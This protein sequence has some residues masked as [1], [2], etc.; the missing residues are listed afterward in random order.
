MN[1]LVKHPTKLLNGSIELPSSKSISNRALI[2]QALC[3]DALQI[4]NLS[5][6]KDT[7]VL[8]E[9]LNGNDRVINIGD[10]GTAMRFLT[11]YLSTQEGTYTIDGSE[12]MRER[13]IKQL[14][15]ALN[16]LGANITY[17][18][19]EGYPPVQINGKITQG[20]SIKIDAGMS[21][22]YLSALLMI[23]PS[24]EGGLTLHLEGRVV[25]KPYIEMTLKMMQYFG[26]ESQWIDNSI[27]I[28]EQSY[29]AK[30]L[31]VEADWSAAAFWF[32]LIAL[33][34]KGTIFMEGL[35]VESW[36]G[37]RAALA[38]FTDLGV[39]YSFN[40]QGLSLQKG[41]SDKQHFSFHLLDTPDLAQTICCTLAG[42][43]K[44]A[45]ISGLQTLNIKET[46]RLKAL[47]KELS[48]MGVH[49]K[50]DKQSIRM[51]GSNIQQSN[52]PLSSYNDHRMAMSLAPLALATD[53]IIIEDIEVVSKS[54][55]TFWDDLKKVGFDI[56][57]SSK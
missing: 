32:E 56:R 38:L 18:E 26:I 9:A 40:E 53:G 12:R 25:S 43:N 11:A 55:P 54:Y 42:L 16:Q 47:Q 24:L 37:D 7:L 57:L 23:A 34:D 50:I 41:K 27:R 5:A 15:A 51:G 30:T 13:P 2:I 49:I 14:V 45:V 46:N 6:A 48:K 17:L 20:G 3:T 31:T 8:Q 33:A 44:T 36:Q 1:Y 39:Q 29:R 28:E 52:N 22:Q 21:S 4:H 19:N 35:Q 10:T